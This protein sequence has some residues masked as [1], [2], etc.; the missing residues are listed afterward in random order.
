M[1]STVL[2]PVRDSTDDHIERAF[3][4]SR[5][6]YITIPLIA[7][8]ATTLCAVAMDLPWSGSWDRWGSKRKR[9]DSAQKAGIP[10]MGVHQALRA[11]KA[12]TWTPLPQAKKSTTAPMTLSSAPILSAGRTGRRRC[13]ISAPPRSASRALVSAAWPVDASAGSVGAVSSWSASAGEG[14]GGMASIVVGRLGLCGRV[15]GAVLP[16][17]LEW[18]G[19]QAPAG[20]PTPSLPPRSYLMS[21]CRGL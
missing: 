21:R 8:V 6:A 15:R 7:R 4:M 17:P 5:T 14:M 3:H 2:I 20:V 11:S 16:M 1:S 9:R 18:A 13:A 10:D 12:K 19:L